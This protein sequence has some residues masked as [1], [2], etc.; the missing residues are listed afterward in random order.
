MRI[1]IDVSVILPKFTLKEIAQLESHHLLLLLLLKELS[2][3]LSEFA[4]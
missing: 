1:R 2:A 3:I 4:E